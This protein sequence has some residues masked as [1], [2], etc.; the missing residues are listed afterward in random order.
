MIAL[1]LF[2]WLHWA[3]CGML[4]PPPR[5]EPDP[6]TVRAPSPDHCTA[7]DSPPVWVY[8]HVLIV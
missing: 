7:R 4:V 3:G 2:F 1:L 8:I 6:L 5:I